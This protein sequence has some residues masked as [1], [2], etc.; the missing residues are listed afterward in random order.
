MKKENE[1]FD[2][3][4]MMRDIRG[5]LHEEYEKDP[6]K[7]KRDLKSVSRKYMKRKTELV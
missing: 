5:K 2:A 3:V 4:K 1:K 6:D 7:R